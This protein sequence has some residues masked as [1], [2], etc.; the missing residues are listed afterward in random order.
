MHFWQEKESAAAGERIRR[1]QDV[2]LA[3][4]GGENIM[5]KECL[6]KKALTA[7]RFVLSGHPS[8][9]GWVGIDE[10]WGIIGGI[11]QN[12]FF[13]VFDLPRDIRIYPA[14]S[15]EVWRDGHVNAIAFCGRVPHSIYYDSDRWFVVWIMTNGNFTRTQWSSA[16][17]SHQVIADRCTRPDRGNDKGKAEGLAVCGRRNFLATTTGWAS[18]W[19][20]LVDRTSFGYLHTQT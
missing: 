20:R 5:A 7:E 19:Q 2:Q 10:A 6:D 9:C 8:A 15:A 11:E 3:E 4:L 17:L 1:R 14:A 13:S 16:M 12:M 18:P